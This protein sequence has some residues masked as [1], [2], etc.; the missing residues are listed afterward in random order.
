MTANN[1]IGVINDIESIGKITREKSIIFHV[2]AA[3][4]TGKLP[5]DLASLNVDLMSFWFVAISDVLNPWERILLTDFSI[6][7]DS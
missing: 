5:I 1:E 3:Q 6:A 4:S 2:D 7:C